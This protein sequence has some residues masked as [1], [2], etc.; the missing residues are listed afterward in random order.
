[1]AKILVA[2]PINENKLDLWDRFQNHLFSLTYEDKKFSLLDN[3]FDGIFSEKIF[4]FDY[5]DHFYLPKAYDRVALARRMAKDIALSEKY[6][7]ILFV[8]SDVFPPKDIINKLLKHK[9][10]VV[11]GLCWTLDKIGFPIPNAWIGG[12][13][14][15][16]DLDGLQEVDT[17]GFGCTLISKKALKN[18]EFQVERNKEGK[19]EV[20]EDFYFCRE[21]KKKGIKIYMDFDTPCKH[22]IGDNHWDYEKD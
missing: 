6:D 1:M 8:D 20:G 11:G 19:L 5:Y 10:D 13:A 9:K 12:K 7:Y 3:S 2:T 4:N 18:S 21:L 14:V 16:P 22:M 15:P 17:V